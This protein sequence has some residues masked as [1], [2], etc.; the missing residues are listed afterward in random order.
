MAIFAV[1]SYSSRPILAA[2]HEARQPALMGD[3]QRLQRK[4]RFTRKFQTFPCR[5]S[6]EPGRNVRL[7]RLAQD[8]CSLLGLRRND[9]A[10]LVLSEPNRMRLE[11]NG[12]SGKLD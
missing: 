4:W 2:V 6:N 5:L 10:P 1:S 7:C 9:I 3:P 11:V 8:T 12:R